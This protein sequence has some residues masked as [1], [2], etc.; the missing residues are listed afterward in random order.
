MNVVNFK[1][2]EAQGGSLR[3]YVSKKS[4]SQF[5]HK[6]NN[7]IKN[8]KNKYNLFNKTTYKIFENKIINCKK[9]L[10]IL[11]KIF[12]KKKLNIAGYGAAAKTTTFLNYFQISEKIVKFIYDDNKL[13]QGLCIPGTKI[14]IINP[15]NLNR[16][17]VDILIIFAWNYSKII[18]SKNNKFKIK[19]GK[20]LI[21]FPNPKLI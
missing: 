11:L 8:E 15:K 9:K 7:Q 20:F 6:I 1:I 13:K 19:G 4:R 21:P 18:M 2:T 17:K 16:K 12:I 14:K 5:Q 3:V 10:N